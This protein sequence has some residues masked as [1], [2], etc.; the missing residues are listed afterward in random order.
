MTINKAIEKASRIHPDALGDDVKSE[1]I[2]ELDGKIA[3]ET[4]HRSGFKP[5]VFPDDA[6]TELLVKAPYDTIYELYIIAMSD[7]F[8][9]EIG[10]YGASAAMFNKAYE[11]YRKQYIRTNMPPQTCITL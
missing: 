6:E 11:E 8:S 4:L 7:F 3:L 1:W 9:G 5:Y 10:N 2:S